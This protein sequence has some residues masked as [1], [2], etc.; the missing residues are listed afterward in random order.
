MGIRSAFENRGQYAE[1]GARLAEVI[2]G[3]IDEAPADSSAN[4]LLALFP[5]P[6]ADPTTISTVELPDAYATAI[7]QSSPNSGKTLSILEVYPKDP[8]EDGLSV[9]LRGSTIRGVSSLRHNIPGDDTSGHQTIPNFTGLH[10]PPI[11]ALRYSAG[12]TPTVIGDL[13]S[14][15]GDFED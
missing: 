4:K 10:V 12:D 5:E 13:L 7:S 6:G 9:T 11:D 8:T 15:F 3:I 2:T 1:D 14:R